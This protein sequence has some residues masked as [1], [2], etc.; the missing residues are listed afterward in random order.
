MR[1]APERNALASCEGQPSRITT[2]PPAVV[3]AA[4]AESH[5]ARLTKAR[6]SLPLT[7][8]IALTLGDGDCDIS[9]DVIEI[10]SDED[11]HD[12]V[13]EISSDDD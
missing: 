9:S 5:F 10:S 3:M 2:N 4:R 12:C 7:H 13:I 8:S 1:Y 11:E 6:A